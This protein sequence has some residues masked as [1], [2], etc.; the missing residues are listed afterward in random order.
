MS[1]TRFT[2]ICATLITLAVLG[3]AP[4][5]ST[6]AVHPSASPA[7]DRAGSDPKAVEI[8][9]QVIVASGGHEKWAAAKQIRWT[10]SIASGEAG[11]PPVTFDEAWDRWNG[12]HHLKMHTPAG[13]VTVMRGLYDD[14]GA[15]FGGGGKLTK[16]ET[17]RVLAEARDR[18]EFDSTPL[19]IA[20]L[21]EAP[22]AKLTLVGERPGEGSE[23]P[24]DELKLTFD[25]K[26]PTRGLTYYALVDRTSHQIVRIEMVKA[27]DPDTKRVGYKITKW[28]D[29][30]GIKL[31]TEFQNVAFASA[32]NTYSDVAVSSEPDDRLYV[33]VAQ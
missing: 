8:A 31:P 7:F 1:N 30:G 19:A 33:P 15:A 17:D 20:F 16:E 24:T 25:P 3:C 29:V 13:D 26:D 28:A 23:P 4:G 9:D 11:K 6:F 21:L 2:F 27:G 22:G 10:Q 5:R 14:K 18:W 12:R 32:V